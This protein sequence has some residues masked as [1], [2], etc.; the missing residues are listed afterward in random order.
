MQPQLEERGTRYHH[1]TKNNIL[2]SIPK[3]EGQFSH[4]YLQQEWIFSGCGVDSAPLLP[5]WPQNVA[6]II[7]ISSKHRCVPAVVGAGPASPLVV[8]GV[9]KS[10]YSG[11]GEW[12]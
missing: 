3:A 5:N 2:A 10:G 6:V 12:C 4:E 11:G 8:Q 1:L 9:K 7:S